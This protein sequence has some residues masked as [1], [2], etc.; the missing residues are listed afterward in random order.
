ME[1]TRIDELAAQVVAWHNRNRLAQRITTDHVRAVG[2]V[3]LPFVLPPG[4][5]DAGLAQRLDPPLLDDSVHEPVEP[6]PDAASD[7]PSAAEPAAAAAKKPTAALIVRLRVF[8]AGLL[9]R[10]PRRRRATGLTAAFSDDFI[11]PMSPQ[12]VARF[13]LKQG[14]GERPGTASW[15][16][17][18]VPVDEDRQ[19]D[20]LSVLYL[21][22]A[23]IELGEHRCRVLIGRGAKPR[24]IGPRAWSVPRVASAAAGA[25]LMAGVAA[26]G[27]LG[28]LVPLGH[29]SVSGDPT[30]LASLEPA[31][32][33]PT[34][35]A[36]ARE[37]ESDHALA[38]TEAAASAASSAASPSAASAPESADSPEAAGAATAAASTS[39]V[40]CRHHPRRATWSGARPPRSRASRHAA[41][42]SCDLSCPMR[43]AKP[44]CARAN[45]CAPCHRPP[46]NQPGPP[47]PCMSTP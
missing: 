37:K 17:R 35:V 32:S 16:Q 46:A 18:V 45:A 13:A 25:T 28:G 29:P 9:Q 34:S 22:T 33:A 26:F 47:A 38:S 10:L 2:V 36:S 3:V 41:V 27:L 23:C 42:P 24:I 15:P 44:P 21:R 31:A 4:A 40:R 7:E 14:S 30:V 19:A 12:R 39:V 20:D 6:Q 11:A 5:P 1:S 8:G 43:C